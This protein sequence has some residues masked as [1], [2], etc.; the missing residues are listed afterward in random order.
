M[1]QMFFE[2]D[3]F[4]EKKAS[5]AGRNWI[6]QTIYYIWDCKDVYGNFTFCVTDF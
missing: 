6:L 2:F 3:I 5:E 1:Q 4:A